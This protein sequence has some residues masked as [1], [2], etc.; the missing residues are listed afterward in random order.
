MALFARSLDDP[1]DGASA[2]IYFRTVVLL[3]TLGSA[4]RI[5]ATRGRANSPGP[6]PT[7]SLMDIT[8]PTSDSVHLPQTTSCS[9]AI[10]GAGGAGPV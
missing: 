6:L 8:Q 4:C 3:V 1:I 2:A 10:V 9:L 7:E 5:R